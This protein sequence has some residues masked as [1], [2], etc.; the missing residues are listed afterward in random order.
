[1]IPDILSYLQE[2]FTKNL[3]AKEVAQKFNLCP[4][5]FS[6]LFN[7]EVGIKFDF[8][9]QQL[10]VNQ[11]KSS[12]D[13]NFSIKRACYES[14]F[15]SESQFHKVFKKRVGLTPKEY[16]NAKIFDKEAIKNQLVDLMKEY[17]SG[18]N[19]ESVE[20]GVSFKTWLEINGHYVMVGH[21]K[22]KKIG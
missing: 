2:N 13:N 3:V 21:N 6:R 9:I 22:F 1:M 11:A 20:W 17:C 12:L 10:R 19:N 18:I 14:G 7:Q 15:Q 5:K 8:Y 16:K 4:F